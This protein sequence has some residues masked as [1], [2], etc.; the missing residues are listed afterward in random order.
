M[1]SRTITLVLCIFPEG[2]T[3]SCHKIENVEKEEEEEEED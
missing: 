3:F 1:L 2:V